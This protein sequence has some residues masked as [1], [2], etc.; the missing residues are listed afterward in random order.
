MI[1]AR[2]YAQNMQNGDWELSTKPFI[3]RQFSIWMTNLIQ[4][5]EIHY[6]LA[7][8]LFM[9]ISGVLFTFS[10]VYMLQ[11]LS[12]VRRV[13]IIA[14]L[15]LS[16]YLILFMY[17]QKPYDLLMASFFTLALTYM[18]QRKLWMYFFVFI[19]ACITKETAILL[20]PLFLVFIGFQWKYIG[21]HLILFVGIQGVIRYIFR[22]VPG[23]GMWFDPLGNLFGHLQTRALID[24]LCLMGCLFFIYRHWQFQHPFLRASAIVLVPIFLFLYG[25]AGRPFEYRSMVEIY[26]TISLLLI[27]PNGNL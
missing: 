5:F 2:P 1:Y 22:D 7:S 23:L 4:S 26:S 8:M 17:H 19:L 16:V 11:T 25:I 6:G 3:Y 9:G 24:I 18:A 13:E 12:R 21:I 20:L 14:L 27:N 15:I 10:L